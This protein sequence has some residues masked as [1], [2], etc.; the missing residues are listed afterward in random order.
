MKRLLKTLNEPFVLWLLSSVVVGIV[1]WQYAEIQKN[2]TARN[3]ETQLLRKAGL[4]LKL[5]LKD[6]QFLVLQGEELTVAQLGGTLKLLQYNALSRNSEYY[7]PS[8]PN[9][10]LEIDARTRSCGLE[11]YQDRIYKYATILS[12]TL[13]NLWSLGVPPNK[14]IYSQL[15]EET[16]AELLEL[17]VLANEIKNYYA[18]AKPKCDVN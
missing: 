15:S 16:S 17:A 3:S 12:A 14:R 6:V 7:I 4:E 2:S 18:E 1:S 8:V 13:N 9:L 10:M 5:Q 11:K